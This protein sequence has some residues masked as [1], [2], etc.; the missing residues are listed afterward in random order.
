[1]SGHIVLAISTKNPDDVH[2][3][4]TSDTWVRIQIGMPQKGLVMP[5]DLAMAIRNSVR[6]NTINKNY[7]FIIMHVNQGKE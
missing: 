4:S 7:E 3:Y 5:H 2:V 6:A 1:M